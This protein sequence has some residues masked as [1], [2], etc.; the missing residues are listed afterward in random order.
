[1]SCNP[2]YAGKKY[3]KINEIRKVISSNYNEVDFM[4][5]DDT[6]ISELS[7][8]AFSLSKNIEAENDVVSSLMTTM[9]NK[10][11]ILRAKGQL[12][13]ITKLL[14]EVKQIALDNQKVFEQHSDPDNFDKE[15]SVKAGAS[16]NPKTNA[17]VASVY[18]RVYDNFELQL[19]PD[20][21]TEFIGYRNKLKYNY[22][23]LSYNSVHLISEEEAD[24]NTDENGDV[25]IEGKNYK[26]DPE[27]SVS[28]QVK[29]LLSEI[30]LEVNGKKKLTPLF[31]YKKVEFG[32]VFN[33]LLENLSN[34]PIDEIIPELED[35]SGSNYI[36]KG[37]LNKIN[38][39]KKTNPEI[40][41]GML[42]VLRKQKAQFISMVFTERKPRLNKDGSQKVHSLTGEPLFS[43]IMAKA[44][45]ANRTGAKDII[46]ANWN[47]INKNQ[48]DSLTKDEKSSI[49]SDFT[50]QISKEFPDENSM[51]DLS[52]T[53]KAV[54]IKVSKEA[55]FKLKNDFDNKKNKKHFKKE[56]QGDYEG[57]DFQSFL[58]KKYQYI[59]TDFANGKDIFE[60]Q[61]GSI[62]SLA[63]YEQKFD[64]DASSQ[65]FRNNNG[66]TIYSFVNPHH[67][68]NTLDK[69]DDIKFQEQLMSDTFAK[70][71][72]WIGNP[73]AAKLF[74]FD[75]SKNSQKGSLA[76]E[77]RDQSKSEK[78]VTKINLWANRGA[79]DYGFMFTP[80]P[81]DKTTF[82]MLKL[83]R[84]ILDLNI[85]KD[86]KIILDRESDLFRDLKNLLVN[87]EIRNSKDKWSCYGCE[88][89]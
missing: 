25:F 28:G 82:S 77:Y 23:Q 76:K 31:T 9:L 35:L 15:K 37:V 51:M 75:S 45:E 60:T 68:S 41:N 79:N 54:G 59:F 2:I 16:S 61:K 19:N 57:L 3:N 87:S 42:S 89:G 48:V 67:L 14:N 66:D 73:N 58:L 78:E 86:E 17:K 70:H 7:L 46:F 64:L 4:P 50:K 55:L 30:P 26:T 5:F 22:E 52:E 84:V 36:A 56:F 29:R 20:G 72:T 40:V 69:L 62:K 21:T 24:A 39:L 74:Y 81:S 44:I 83:K 53:F 11:D 33:Y 34:L 6:D 27:K 43:P 65:S 32:K 88:W 10:M 12:A 18:K 13:S 71:S 1:M 85:F 8:S 47:E 63:I 49:L 38:E 80:S